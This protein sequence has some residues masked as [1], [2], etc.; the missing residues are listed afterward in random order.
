[1]V[2][3]RSIDVTLKPKQ[4]YELVSTYLQ[5]KKFKINKTFELAPFEKDHAAILISQ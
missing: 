4:A 5:Q 1:M 3:A 2:K